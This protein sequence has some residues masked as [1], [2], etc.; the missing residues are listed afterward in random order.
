[1]VGLIGVRRWIAA[2][3]SGTDR[4]P[5]HID[6]TEPG[7]IAVPRLAILLGV[8]A[9]LASCVT[10]Y[11]AFR[12][13][14]E[15]IH[16]TIYQ[17]H[18]NV[19]QTMA[20]HS[21]TLPAAT[22]DTLRVEAVEDLWKQLGHP[23]RNSYVCVVD[24]D[25]KLLLH[26]IQPDFVGRDVG[27]LPV[28]TGRNSGPKT[29]R[30]LV[31]AG[32]DWVGEFTSG[33]GELQVA[34]CARSSRLG[35]MVMIHTPAEEINSAV[36]GSVVPW[37]GG[38]AFTSFL[39]IPLSLGLLYWA[40]SDSMQQRN[41]A[42]GALRDS[43]SFYQSLVEHLPQLIFR[44]DLDGRMTFVN[45]NLCDSIG[46]HPDEI[47]G[48]TD[49]D[50]YPKTLAEKYR[51]DDLRVMETGE[52]FE[53]VEDHLSADGQRQFVRVV[54]YPI[55]NANQQIVGIQGIFWDITKR[56]QVQLALEESEQRLRDAQRIAQIGSFE[57][58][59]HKDELWWSDELHHLF[60]LEPEH[61]TPTKDSFTALLHP[62]D[63]VE[64]I[65]ALMNALETG[66]HFRR[67]YRAKHASGEW[68][69]FETVADVT[70][71]DTGEI[72]GLR[73]TLQDITGQRQ[74]QNSLLASRQRL[75]A[76]FIDSPAGLAIVDDQLRYVQINETLASINGSTVEEH[77]GRTA[78]QIMPELAPTI[79]PMFQKV[80]SEGISYLNVEVNGETPNHPG[81]ERQWMVSYFPM[82][83]LDGST[84]SVGVVV[85]ET[86]DRKRAE[87]LLRES[88]EKYRTLVESSPYS[89]HQ[90][91]SNGQMVSMNRPPGCGEFGRNGRGEIITR[92]RKPILGRVARREIS[93]RRCRN[94]T[95]PPIGS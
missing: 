29:I 18:L 82:R 64:Y 15:T 40:H 26:T 5:A 91:D 79:E 84:E 45:Q 9:I 71:G 57:G 50:L 95:F 3:V 10:G 24:A 83:A 32:E 36:S 92:Q 60:G 16:E 39:L 59:I 31:S 37:V 35:G 44:K 19:A 53:A 43:Q 65:A 88:E 93:R 89:V 41:R 77:I 33:K 34:A 61:F 20:K 52:V 67:Q 30:A 69:H 70:F 17:G 2:N 46:L 13:S 74:M 12:S 76:F 4:A 7:R 72:F 68:R 78:Q 23:Y 28:E 25:G 38:L 75:D 55:R 54:K 11:F 42:V 1:V 87:D 51:A 81:V 58:D 90:I 21:D 94:R 86:T 14:R 62:D 56:R 63:K 6:T 85:I 8:S 47:L 48:H 22:S 49:I 80:L 66:E 27:D 73:G